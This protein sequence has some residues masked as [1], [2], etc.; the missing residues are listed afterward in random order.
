MSANDL[1][2]DSTTC[3]DSN[4]LRKKVEDYGSAI[5]AFLSLKKVASLCHH[6][7]NVVKEKALGTEQVDLARSHLAMVRANLDAS[8]EKLKGVE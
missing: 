4:P 3:G 7:N 2:G 5:S 8:V 1:Q 6:P